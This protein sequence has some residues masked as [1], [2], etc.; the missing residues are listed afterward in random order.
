MYSH[1]IAKKHVIIPISLFCQLCP[2]RDGTATITSHDG[3]C[4]KYG[5]TAFI[6]QYV[7][8]ANDVEGMPQVFLRHSTLFCSHHNGNT[9]ISLFTFLLFIYLAL[10]VM[11]ITYSILI[12]AFSN[13]LGIKY[14]Y[15]YLIFLPLNSD[16]GGRRH[17]LFFLPVITCY[18]TV[19]SDA[20]Q[21][22]SPHHSKDYT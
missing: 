10:I 13:K 18:M 11:C 22:V 5:N 9:G 3:S 21:L 15:I 14:S 12:C 4:Q 6:D 7:Y 1:K 16:E 19:I 17:S 2:T 20:V 8:D